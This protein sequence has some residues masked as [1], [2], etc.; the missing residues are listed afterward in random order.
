VVSGAP[1]ASQ[2]VSR[3]SRTNT[4][5][6]LRVK[7]VTTSVKRYPN[8]G[9]LRSLAGEMTTEFASTCASHDRKKRWLP[10]C[11]ATWKRCSSAR[12]IDVL[13]IPPELRIASRAVP[14]AMSSWT[15]FSTTPSLP[16]N[17]VGFAGSVAEMLTSLREDQSHSSFGELISPDVRRRQGRR[18]SV[19]VTVIQNRIVVGDGT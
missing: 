18:T 3:L 11:R 19:H 1:R 10:K 13:P 9:S 4:T 17:T 15:A 7:Q 2:T 14:G 12:A 6:D 16:W 8:A 5:Y